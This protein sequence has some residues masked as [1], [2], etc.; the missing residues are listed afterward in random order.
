[1]PAY[2]SPSVR[3]DT[4]HAQRLERLAGLQA[5][6]A[7]TFVLA[8]HSFVEGVMRERLR[9]EEGD[10]E[11]FFALLKRYSVYCQKRIGGPGDFLAVLDLLD[12]AH[13]P[14]NSVRHNFASVD[15]SRAREATQHLRRFCQLSAIDCP[16]ELAKLERYLSAWE[17]RKPLGALVDELAAIRKALGSIGTKGTMLLDRIAELDKA[18]REAEHFR[19]EIKAR[20]RRIGELSRVSADRGDKVDALRQER[21][22]LKA[23]REALEKEL[24]EAN[25]RAAAQADARAYREALLAATTYTRTRADYEKTIIRLTPEQKTILRQIRLDA[26]FLVKGAAG[27]GKTLVLL[28]AIRKAKGRGEQAELGL[29][30]LSGSIA[31]LTYTKALTKY[32][33]Y[34]A[35]LLELD[36]GD[37]IQ[38]AFAFIAERFRKLVPDADIS[39]K[40]AEED[41]SP[42]CPSWMTAREFCAEADNFIWA[43]LVTEKEYVS[44]SFPRRGM[45][46]PLQVKQREVLWIALEAMEAEL[47]G[48]KRYSQNLAARDLVRA[49][50]TAGGGRGD[51]VDYIFLDE[52][53]DLCAA[54]LAAIKASSRKALILA[55]DGDQSIYQPF[56]SFERA[57][58]DIV[59]RTRVLRTNFRNTVQLHDY[60]ERYRALGAAVGAGVDAE[61]LPE[62]FR[63]GPE[64]ELFEGR[65]VPELLELV[66]RHVGLY[67]D[68]L[69][70]DAENIAILAP[71][72]ADLDSLAAA[73]DAAGHPSSLVMRDAFDF[74]ETGRVRLSTLHSAKG[75]DFPVVFLWIPRLHVTDAS[76]EG[77]A[78]DRLNR[79]L[80][81]VGI[82]RA[83]DHCAIFV[84]EGLTTP[85]VRDLV[86]AMAGAGAGRSATQD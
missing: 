66:T 27:T 26:D 33:R 15:T 51:L 60:A 58:I 86:R 40:L 64:P 84:K 79:N 45:K 57:G 83:M 13:Q 1:M 72:K 8:V 48:R 55:G 78:E 28:E 74:D 11:R 36:T 20:D 35:R 71:T 76:W 12:N 65:D 22:G 73:L 21:A 16:E 44:E 54:M 61:S 9:I 38:T 53:Q 24:H 67:R 3:L 47:R 56:T 50:A 41:A 77:G 4:T 85:A 62:A 82:T 81:Y 5:T 19:E 46:K 17:E 37:R 68:Q 63:D 25:A 70:Y 14:T 52:T 18:E 42:F 23:E 59:G 43:N 6:D 34:L 7:G 30:E 49:T 75:L 69:G 10:D 39:L 32:D 29:E 2:Q 31:L 80:L